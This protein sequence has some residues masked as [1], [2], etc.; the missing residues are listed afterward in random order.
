MMIIAKIGIKGHTWGYFE[1]RVGS[2]WPLESH[3]VQIKVLSY[4][5]L[6]LQDSIHLVMA[7]IGI[8]VQA[9]LRL[10]F[11]VKGMRGKFEFFLH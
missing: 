6:E 2:K 3:F 8:M 10:E 1:A 7:K 5:Y 4:S 11:N 9:D